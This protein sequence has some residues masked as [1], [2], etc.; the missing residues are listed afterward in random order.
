MKTSP[1]WLVVRMKSLFRKRLNKSCPN[2]KVTPKG[3]QMV[4][5]VVV[6]DHEEPFLSEFDKEAMD[7]L[8]AYN[9]RTRLVI[10]VAMPALLSLALC[11]A[12]LYL[13]QP[14]VSTFWPADLFEV[15]PDVNEAIAC[16][17]APAGLV[18]ATSFAF[19]FEQALGKQ[20]EIMAKIGHE[21]GLLDQIVTITSKLTLPSN[22]DRMKIY[23]FERLFAI[24]YVVVCVYVVVYFDVVSCSCC[25]L[26]TGNTTYVLSCIFQIL[27]GSTDHLTTQ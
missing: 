23:R 13:Y 18:Y 27:I 14:F 10:K 22:Q 24:V 3:F 7:S 9:G 19:A 25:Y 17:L 1:F 11:P 21:L 6:Q 20:R 26:R 8:T 16:F 12:T 4:K 5:S 2:N 15:P